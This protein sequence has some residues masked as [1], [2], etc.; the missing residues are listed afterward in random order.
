ME[1]MPRE[2]RACP[3]KRGAPVSWPGA[4]GPVPPSRGL[5]RALAPLPAAGMLS[6]GYR[7]LS[8]RLFQSKSS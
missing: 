2:V 6:L 4:A 1:I 7:S 8:R 3:G 5:A